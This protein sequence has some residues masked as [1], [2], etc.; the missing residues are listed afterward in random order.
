MAGTS[1]WRKGKRG[2]RLRQEAWERGTS[3]LKPFV[4]TLWVAKGELGRRTRKENSVSDHFSTEE[5]S[6]SDHFAQAKASEKGSIFLGGAPVERKNLSRRKWFGSLSAGLLGWMFTAAGA[7]AE[8]RASPPA[9]VPRP[10]P[11]RTYSHSVTS[12]RYDVNSRLICVSHSE[13]DASGRTT[14]CVYEPG[15]DSREKGKKETTP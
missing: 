5:N 7:S 13:C 3:D 8:K 15:W 9:P 11:A 14:S 1:S 10:G 6:V 2:H 12:F 4:G